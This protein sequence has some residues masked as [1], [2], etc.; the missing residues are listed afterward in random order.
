[1]NC[2]E[3]KITIIPTA[4]GSSTLCTTRFGEQHYH[5]LRG[6]EGEAQHVFIRFLED[7]M[8]VLEV[9][10]GSGLNALLSL[11]SGL[12]LKY[13]TIELYPIEPYILSQI[14]FNSPELQAL[15]QCRW[16]EWCV[17]SPNFSLR[18][19]QLDITHAA[20]L[21]TEEFDI[22]FFDAFAPDCVPEQWSV[23]VFS[24]ISERLSTGAKL[25]TYSAKGVIKRALREA[26]FEVK[27]LPGA[28][29]KHNMVVATKPPH[30]L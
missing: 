26:G 16:E 17:I 12:H 7:G 5:S 18:K 6:A 23:T 3:H 19:L 11:K 22:V 28:L 13:T 4:D 15:H 2:K 20:Q 1:M 21:P 29:G 9:G 14:S 10:F 24:E 30:P 8:R 25:L 27:R